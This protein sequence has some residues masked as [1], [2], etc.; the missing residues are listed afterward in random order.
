ML[1]AMYACVCVAACPD[2]PAVF[3]LC[4][5]SGTDGRSRTGMK[6]PT[7]VVGRGD[8]RSSDYCDLSQDCHGIACSYGAG[9][10][11]WAVKGTLMDNLAWTLQARSELQLEEFAESA[12]RLVR[13]VDAFLEPTIDALA[14][15]GWNSGQTFALRAE[16]AR[17]AE[18]A[19]GIKRQDRK[20]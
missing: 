17:A 15:E 9:G 5:A 20:S 6:P 1:C 3:G 18:C 16:L 19:E 8:L 14:A 11:P 12:R 10:T 7:P 2:L 13:L 4:R